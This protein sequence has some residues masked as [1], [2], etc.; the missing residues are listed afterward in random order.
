LE[1]RDRAPTGDDW[2]RAVDD[3]RRLASDADAVFDRDIVI[4][5]AAIEPMATFGVS[6]DAAGPAG[7]VHPPAETKASAAA[8]DYMGMTPGAALSD[9]AVDRV[10]IGSC[11][12]SRLS[13]LRAAADVV[14]GRKVAARVKML[15]APGSEKIKRDAEAEGL[16]KVF[17][18]AGAEW[19]EPGC[20]M[21]IAMNGDKGAPGELVVSTSNRNFKGRQGEGVRTVLA[22]PATAAASAVAG[23]IADPRP[24]LDQPT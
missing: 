6:P 4:D 8:A 22:S 17:T 13:D 20:S 23:R 11:T 9:V 10:F 12:N 1:G 5:A 24:Y 19:R 7:G 14:R 3:W 18:D 15:V 2:L 16:D 21:C